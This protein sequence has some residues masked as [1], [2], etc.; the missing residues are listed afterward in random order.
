MDDDV[1]GYFFVPDMTLVKATVTL[2][3]KR[4]ITLLIPALESIIK[5]ISSKYNVDEIDWDRD[6]EPVD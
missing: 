4:P 2:E 1:S 6:L 3:Y 5:P